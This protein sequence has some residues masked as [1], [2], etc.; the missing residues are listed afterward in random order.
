MDL[1]SER[2][3]TK[4]VCMQQENRIPASTNDGTKGKG[5]AQDLTSLCELPTEV[6]GLVCRH[7]PSRSLC[8]LELVSHELQRAMADSGAWRAQALTVC[9]QSDAPKIVVDMIKFIKHKSISDPRAFKVVLGTNRMV[10]QTLAELQE[11]VS[12]STFVPDPSDGV[13]ASA[14]KAKVGFNF[15]SVT[16]CSLIG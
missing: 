7:L 2:R 1:A 3:E 14:A 13:F 11:V 12:S 15:F 16:S 10:D 6:I 9:Q 4:R 8:H 5:D